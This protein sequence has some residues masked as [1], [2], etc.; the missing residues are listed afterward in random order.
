MRQPVTLLLTSLGVLLTIAGPLLNSH[1]FGNGRQAAIDGGL[2]FQFVFGLIL[3]GY[4]ACSVMS[5]GRTSGTVAALLSK[6]VSRDS[7]FLAEFCGISA[8]VIFYSA[9]LAAATML[10]ERIAVRYTPVDGFLTDF[11][12]A[13]AALLCL[14]AACAIG[15]FVNFRYQRSFQSS[16]AVTLLLMLGLLVLLSGFFSRSGHWQRY[17]CN[18]DLRI[19]PAALIV[20]AGL[21]LMTA[22]GLTLAVRLKPGAV[23]FVCAALLIGGLIAGAAPQ[24][25]ALSLGAIA[26]WVLPDWR[27]FMVA[28]MLSAGGGM[29]AGYLRDLL[30]YAAL[31]SGGVLWIGA[32]LFRKADMT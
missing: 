16:T 24:S 6:P 30:L 32:A 1:N 9:C 2:A 31:Y 19:V 15:G 21:L 10:A 17:S 12:L 28:D 29:P 26:G 11:H 25:P 5:R 23:L 20:G 22:W 13:S 4:S 3:A 27:N 8:V 14:P 7:F 18:L